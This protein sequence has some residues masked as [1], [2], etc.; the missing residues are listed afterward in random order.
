MNKT[1]KTLF[2]VGVLFCLQAN[3][4]IKAVPFIDKDILYNNVDGVQPPNNPQK[5][6]GTITDE[7]GE[8]I[9]GASVKERDTTNGTVT[10]FDGKFTLNVNKGA[11]LDISYIGYTAKSIQANGQ[12]LSITLKEDSRQLDELVVVGYGTQ[13]KVNLTGAVSAIGGKELSKR[14]VSQSS[15]ALQGAAP[16]VTI[17]QRSGQPGADGGD[18]KIR[19][20]GT[21][22]NANPLIL[23]DGIEMGL[24]NIDVSTIESISVLKDAASAS[25]Y[26]SKAANGVI[27]V[28]TK[29][30]ATG[31]FAISYSGYL[32]KQSPT[33]LPKKLNAIDHMTLL[34][35]A[36]TNSGAG[37]VYT[38]EQIEEWRTKGP[39][40]RDHYPDTDWQKEV[41]QGSGIQQSHTVTMSGG[42]DKLKVLASLGY[43]RQEGIVKNS[44]YQRIFMR[45]NTDIAFTK[46]FSSSL[47]VFIYNAQ[48]NSVANYNSASF[49][50]TGMGYIFFLM[51]KLPAVQAARYSNGLYAEGQNGE[52]PVASLNEGGFYKQWQTPITANLSFKWNPTKDFW[53]DAAFA[54]SLSYPQSK[55]F[56]NK[57][58]TYNLDGSV[59][60]TLPSKNSLT[61]QADYS[62]YLQ[63]KSTA[64]YKKDIKKHSI[65]AMAGFQYETMYSS[66]F[67]AFRD[68]F[69]FSG[70]TELQAGSVENMK[71][72]GWAS[73]NVLMSWFGRVNYDFDDRYLF[74]ANIRYDGSSKFAKGHKWGAFPSFSAGWRISEESFWKDIKSYVPY[75]KLRAS[76]GTLG[77]QSID[78]NYPFS[79]NVD[80]STKYISNDVLVDGA[81]IITMSNPYI[82]WETTRMTNIGLDMNLLNNKLNVSFDWYYKKTKD[83][84]LKLDIPRTIGLNA[85]YQN[86]GVVENKGYELNVTYSDHI[87]DFNFDLGLNFADVKNKILSLKGIN[88]TGLVTN[89]EGY[90]INSLYM[91]KSMGILSENDFNADG[92]YKW[93]RQIRN[94]APGDLRYA[95]LNGDDIVNDDDREV[96]GSTIPRYTFGLS[97]SGRYKGFDLNFLLQGVGKVDGY[98]TALSQPFYSG[99]T[100]FEIHKNRWTK[101]NPNPNADFPRLYFGDNNNYRESDFYKKSAAYA[102]L[103]NIQLGYTIPASITRKAFIEHLRMYVTGENL[104]TVTSFWDGWDPEL[105]PGQSGGYYPQVKS[106]GFGVDIRF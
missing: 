79:S 93:T 68:N 43:F 37:A 103:K 85:T 38:P 24:D 2:V 69:L 41:L 12:H 44:S 73:E 55:S 23:V 1:K 87:G 95:N 9:I 18:I 102:R 32:S 96:L 98:L 89:R 63:F 105:A 60:S 97:F 25:I 53:M 67:N 72:D 4:A 82:T 11:I 51:N 50:G 48:N 64:N 6:T 106:I 74:E 46:N 16:G 21:L 100:A 45:L 62:R 78:D 31:K 7:N 92:S 101:E 86:A 104:L 91:F 13:K 27:L 5:I 22:N 19:G 58:T 88:G 75:L 8:P 28:T 40:D 36:K 70:Y 42:T 15:M 35:E 81:S 17:T 56:V 34:N 29:R 54:P 94:L 10:D 99:G 76:W 66:G 59:F 26:G 77:N 3:T 65:S 61:M 57:V 84:L 20:I 90:A 71:N 33:N 39:S 80:M 83:I 52:N 49:N 30:A 47:D 14:Q